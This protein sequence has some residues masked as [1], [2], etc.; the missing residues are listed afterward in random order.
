MAEPEETEGVTNDGA[1]LLLRDADDGDMPG[2]LEIRDSAA[3]HGDR[4]RDAR[5]GQFRYLVAE[6]EGLVSGFGQL[7]LGQPPTWPEVKLVPTMVDLEVRADMRSRGIGSFMIRAMEELARQRGHGE[8]YISTDPDG[9][10]RALVLYARLGYAAMQ[11]KPYL[12]RWSFTSSDGEVHT[13][14]E[15]IVDMRKAL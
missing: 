1:Q 3:V 9:N 11:D 6:C 13:G 8:M 7:V 2:L 4:I 15:W 14:E 10:A 5:G 12:D